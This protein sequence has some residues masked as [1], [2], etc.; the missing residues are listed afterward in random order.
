MIN[1]VNADLAAAVARYDRPNTS[2]LE[3]KA[4]RE[5]ATVLDMFP[6]QA[7]PD[8]PLERYALGAVRDPVPFCAM[9]EYHTPD[10]GSMKGGSARK[11]IIFRHNDGHWWM[12]GSLKELDVHEAWQRLRTEY[13]RAIESV[14]S[15]DLDSLDTFLLLP[16]GGSVVTKTLTIYAPEHFLPINSAGHLRG[17]IELFGAEPEPD[18]SSWLLN[19][20]LWSIVRRQ[21]DFADWN[22]QQILRFLYAHF[23]P[24]PDGTIIKIAPGEQGRMWS[25]CLA[26]NAILVGWDAVGRLVV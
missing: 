23:D 10:L 5:R 9:L 14:T 21:P 26:R 20:Q 16:Y 24:R 18:T 3:A 12:A 1:S 11:H 17:F 19:R 25:A 8:L 13:V 7:W 22:S 15:G 2:E 6:P 4:S